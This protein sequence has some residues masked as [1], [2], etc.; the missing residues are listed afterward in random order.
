MSSHATLCGA[1]AQLPR[2]I[3]LLSA[4]GPR[5][6]RVCVVPG[7]P[8]FRRASTTWAGSPLLIP[9]LGLGRRYVQIVGAVPSLK[10]PYEHPERAVCTLP[11][12]ELRLGVPDLDGCEFVVE[13]DGLLAG[14]PCSLGAVDCQLGGPLW[15]S[16]LA[17]S[18]AG[19]HP[20]ALR[21]SSALD[22]DR[23]PTGTMEPTQAPRSR[24]RAR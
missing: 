4:S 21:P 1:Q 2:L 12:R 14:R 23:C 19:E 17:D 10:H 18:G 9:G 16:S 8:S 24:A 3:K 22:A 6:P 5:G 13:R 11:Q 7:A 15:A 20:H